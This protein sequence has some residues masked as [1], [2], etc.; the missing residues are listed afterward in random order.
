MFGPNLFQDVGVQ[1][2]RKGEGVRTKALQYMEQDCIDKTMMQ[3]LVSL[4]LNSPTAQLDAGAMC[5]H[6]LTMV[7]AVS[8]KAKYHAEQVFNEFGPYSMLANGLIGCHCSFA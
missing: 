6:P 1:W 8:P 5:F 2:T 4:V 3:L 7:V